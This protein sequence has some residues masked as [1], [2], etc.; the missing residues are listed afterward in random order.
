MISCKGGREYPLNAAH[1]KG[2]RLQQQPLIKQ[3]NWA[4]P[5]GTVLICD[6]SGA[7]S[8]TPSD[9]SHLKQYYP[10]EIPLPQEVYRKLP[11]QV[12]ALFS[13]SLVPLSKHC[14]KCHFHM[15]LAGSTAA[16]CSILTVLGIVFFYK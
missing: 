12:F 3:V 6:V 9:H 11:L 15:A 1:H 8:V 7:A 13:F 14:S 5:A 2:R 4:H 16:P 10:D